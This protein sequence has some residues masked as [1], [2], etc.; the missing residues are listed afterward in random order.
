MYTR[1]RG[2]A[3]SNDYFLIDFINDLLINNLVD[4]TSENCHTKKTGTRKYL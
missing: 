4:K 3:E 2:R 1:D